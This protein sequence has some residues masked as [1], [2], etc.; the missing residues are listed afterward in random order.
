MNEFEILDQIFDSSFKITTTSGAY[1]F[2]ESD[3]ECKSVKINVSGQTFSL[4]LD[5]GKKVFSCFDSSISNI[6][7]VNDGVIFFKKG[8]KFVVLLIELKSKNSTGYLNQLKS[9]Q[10]FI[11]YVIQQINLHFPIDIKKVEFRGVLFELGRR[12]ISKNTTKRTPL[13]FEDRNGLMCLSIACNREYRLEQF[14]E[15]L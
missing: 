4:S 7:K 13:K 2:K 14:R 9:G 11:K 15:A 5:N 10:N 12:S 1:E 3:A 8:E 6:T